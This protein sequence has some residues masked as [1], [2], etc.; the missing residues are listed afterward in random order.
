MAR[1]SPARVS[2]QRRHDEYELDL[3]AGAKDPD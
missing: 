1:R 3:I 2:W